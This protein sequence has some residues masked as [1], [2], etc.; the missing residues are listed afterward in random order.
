MRSRAALSSSLLAVMTLGGAALLQAVGPVPAA[1]AAP[2]SFYVDA[3]AGKDS[4]AG[5][6]AAPFK[7]LAKVSAVGV[8]VGDKIFLHRGQTHTGRLTVAAGVTVN[9]YDSGAMPTI[10]GGNGGVCVDVPGDGAVIMNI[11]ASACGTFGFLLRGADQQLLQVTSRDNPSPG[12]RL[13]PNS[14][15]ALVDDGY[16]AANNIGVAA[17]GATATISNSEFTNNT[18]AVNVS[19]TNT[20]VTGNTITGGD[21]GVVV[22]NAQQVVIEHN[23]ATGTEAFVRMSTTDAADAS[24]AVK[25]FYNRHWTTAPVGR[26]ATLH[27]A[28]GTNP[29]PVTSVR[30]SNNSALLSGTDAKAITCTAGCTS[31]VLNELRGNVLKSTAA[32]F[33][34]DGVTGVDNVYFGAEPVKTGASSYPYGAGETFA[35]PQFADAGVGDL[36]IAS[37]SPAVDR[38]T[39][40]S[41]STAKSDLDGTPTWTGS[42]ALVDGDGNGTPRV[43]AGAYEAPAVTPPT[44][45]SSRACPAWS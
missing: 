20:A 28:G 2:T 43:D 32:A 45:S 34:T 17:L 7:S 30:V 8:D 38:V 15:N 3:V 37:G 23:N 10:T 40:P 29:G 41:Y 16:F 18:Q 11:R 4:N 12:V 21:T 27:G 33:T 13:A 25:I 9:A 6:I 36:H 42:A 14:T 5:T 24:S 26:F 39:A 31:T 1:H 19:G 44:P 22:V 35:Q